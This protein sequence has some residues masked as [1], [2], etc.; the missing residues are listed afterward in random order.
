MFALEREARLLRL[1]AKGPIAAS[2]CG[3][4]LAACGDLRVVTDGGRNSH[5]EYMLAIWDARSGRRLIRTERRDDRQT[6]GSRCEV[7]V[8]PLTTMADEF[9]G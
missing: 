3:Q 9:I 2:S 6:W 7:A 5:N 4:L 8:A 1:L